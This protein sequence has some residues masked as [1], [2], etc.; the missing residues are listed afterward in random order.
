MMH[1]FQLQKQ[2]VTDLI[3][4]SGKLRVL[5]VVVLLYKEDIMFNYSPG[6]FPLRGFRTA[7]SIGVMP[8]K[9]THNLRLERL[10]K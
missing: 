7:H 2:R 4:H 9:A 1:K 8:V 6:N 5:D 3:T 10:S